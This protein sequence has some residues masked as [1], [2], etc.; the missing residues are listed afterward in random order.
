VNS[1]TKVSP[2]M[3]NNGRN[4]RM[5]FEMRKKGKVLRAEEFGVKMKEIQEEAQAALR[6]AQEEMK[7]Q[8]DWQRGEV[9]EYKVEDMV[10]L[11][12]RDLK[13]QMIGRRMDKL[14][15]RFVGPYKVKG[16]ISS[17]AIE[18]DLPSSVRI[19]PVVNVSRIHRYRDQVKGQKVTPPPPVEIQGEMEY[20][21]EK[22]LSKRKRYGKVE[23]LVRW[24]GYTA[25]EDTWEK[26]GN[27]GNMQ[28]AVEDYERE[29]KKTARR[30]REKKDRA[31]SRSELPGRYTAKVLYGWDDG[32]FE[33]EYLKKLERNWSRWKGGKFFQR[34]NLKRGGNVM[35]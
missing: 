2:F 6:K 21:V 27:L 31:Y 20:E 15:E 10:L 22:I 32:K 29:Y 24:K 1:S 33:R 19:H 30:I 12:T 16:I 28:E 4:P 17:N 26:K 8:A 11:S 14:T 3:A 23:Y 34:K 18:L 25:E 7:K 35:N 5:G 9:E 13:W